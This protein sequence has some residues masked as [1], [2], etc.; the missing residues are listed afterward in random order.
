MQSTAYH[1]V[2]AFARPTEQKHHLALCV[3]AMIKG[4]NLKKSRQGVHELVCEPAEHSAAP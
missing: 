1:T 4:H 3:G 2:A